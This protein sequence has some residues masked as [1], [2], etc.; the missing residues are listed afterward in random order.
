M[1]NAQ[2]GLVFSIQHFCI[3]DGR[4]IRSTVFLCGCPLRCMWCHNPEGQALGESKWADGTPIGRYMSVGEVLDDIERDRI[5]YDES[6]GGITLSGGEPMMQF[7]FAYELLKTAKSRGLH[8]ALE[9][10]GYAPIEDYMCILPYVDELLWDC[11]LVESSAHKKYTG[12]GNELILDNLRQLCA[13][14]AAVKLRCP[15][16]PGVNDTDAHFEAV[17]SLVRELGISSV[18]IMPYHKLGIS[19]AKKLGREYRE[20]CVPTSA[21][22]KEW[23]KKIKI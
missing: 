12:V 11:K 20:F 19:K 22:K 1:N 14:G 6:G 21:E 10:S 8:T 7:D 5:F 18:K 13:K 23:N 3:H 17:N 15:I 16:I 4:G 9:T 2:K